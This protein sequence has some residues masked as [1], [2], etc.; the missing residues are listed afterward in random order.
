MILPWI[1][2]ATVQAAVYTRLSRGSLLDTLGEDY[3]R[4]ARAKGLSERRV[5]YRHG[6]ARRA[7]PGRVPA[8]H[9]HRR[10]ARRGRGGGGGLRPRRPR[11]GFGQRH[12]HRGP[13]GDH[14]LRAGRR[15]V[16]GGGE[17]HRRPGS[18]RCSTRAS[19]SADHGRAG[20]PTAALAR[21]RRRA[22]NAAPAARSVRTSMIRSPTGRP[23]RRAGPRG[24]Q[25]AHRAARGRGQLAEISAVRS[26][27]HAL[28]WPR[29]GRLLEFREDA[30]AV[31]VDHHHA[32]V[33]P[34]LGGTEHQ[35]GRVVQEGQVT[36]ES[37]G[38]SPAAGLMRE[39]RADRRGHQPVDAARAAAGQHP[40]ARG[41]ICRSRS[42]TGRLD[43]AHSSAPSGSA[44]ARSLA[45]PGS[46]PRAR[47]VEHRVDGA[48]TAASARR[49]EPAPLCRRA[50]GGRASRAAGPWPRRWRSG[51]DRPSGPGPAPGPRAGPGRHAPAQEG[52]LAAGQAAGPAET[53][54]SGRCAATNPAVSSR[55]G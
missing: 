5:I 46:S 30:A 25:A 16:R 41:A 40:Q 52:E 37:A 24:A 26:A 7:D 44:A 47:S 21:S 33:R 51:P 13:A 17:H 49:Q 1:T 38:R 11:L 10:P 27:E 55:Y 14:R 28:E 54:S 22:R 29:D 31:V 35:S 4:T 8:R 39:R 32:Q 36:E 12:Q 34:R 53:I 15:A 2:L 18:T 20:A 45:S 42:R 9:R 19:G 50:A 43:A 6:A 48:R 23:A 3:I